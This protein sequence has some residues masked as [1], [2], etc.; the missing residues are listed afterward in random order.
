[1]TQVQHGGNQYLRY[2]KEGIFGGDLSGV[3]GIQKDSV[4]T[5]QLRHALTIERPTCPVEYARSHGGEIEFLPGESEG[6]EIT[7]EGLYMA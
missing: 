2:R 1:M 5:Q 4:K 7:L 6:T 3:I